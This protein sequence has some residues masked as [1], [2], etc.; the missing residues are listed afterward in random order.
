MARQRTRRIV[1]AAAGFALAVGAVADAA[2]RSAAVVD[3]VLARVPGS[4]PILRADVAG[5]A[6]AVTSPAV[7]SQFTPAEV[8]A[9]VLTELIGLDLDKQLANG[10]GVVPDARAAAENLAAGVRAAG[11]AAAYQQQL[12][13]SPGKGWAGAEVY[14]LDTEI[15][16]QLAVAQARRLSPVPESELRAEYD[17]SLGT[18]QHAHVQ[19]ITTPDLAIA[20]RVAALARADPDRFP[21]LARAD[22]DDDTHRS[23]GGDYGPVLARGQLYADVDAAIFAAAPGAVLG[24]IA[25][26]QAR[27]EYYVVHVLGVVDIPLSAV[28]PA[29]S[30][31][32][33]APDGSY[34]QGRLTAARQRLAAG[35]SVAPDAGT[36]SVRNLRVVPPAANGAAAPG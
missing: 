13:R 2:T 36:F 1:V 24:P 14:A 33:L 5:R 23:A 7:A 12:I 32:V 30:A 25:V 19:I 18:Y 15:R 26:A 31:Q 6:R 35:V 28:I 27:P 3:P 4:P 17:A 8:T 11:T 22:T 9:N 20:T 29:L 34:V 10:L 21:A 16:T